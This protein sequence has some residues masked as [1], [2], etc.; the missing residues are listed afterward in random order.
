VADVVPWRPARP[1]GFGATMPDGFILAVFLWA[2]GPHAPNA[3]KAAE[4]WAFEVQTKAPAAFARR[5]GTASTAQEAC[6]KAEAALQDLR[7]RLG[8]AAP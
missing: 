2:D 6:R 4:P 7:H 1:N 5:H 8:P 3:E